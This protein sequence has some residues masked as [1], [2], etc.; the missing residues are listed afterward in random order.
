MIYS[1]SLGIGRLKSR[2]LHTPKCLEILFQHDLDIIRGSLLQV[3]SR[4]QWDAIFCE[5]NQ[6]LELRDMDCQ[7]IVS[8]NK[9]KG[10]WMCMWQE[11]VSFVDPGFDRILIYGINSHFPSVRVITE[12]RSRLALNTG[13]WCSKGV[14]YIQA[15]TLVDKLWNAVKVFVSTLPSRLQP[16]VSW[17][18][19]WAIAGKNF[20]FLEIHQSV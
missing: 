15:S 6:G 19:F 14:T 8:I 2:S 4:P 11:L 9:L 17:K 12:A 3:Y 5:G 20:W 7:R 18:V 10:K 13:I 16:T 1:K